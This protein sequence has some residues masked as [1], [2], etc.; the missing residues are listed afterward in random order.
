MKTKKERRATMQ[1]LTNA[2]TIN[3]I[4]DILK[5]V[6]GPSNVRLYVSGFS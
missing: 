3:T 5:E 2:E 6:D 1:I 4:K